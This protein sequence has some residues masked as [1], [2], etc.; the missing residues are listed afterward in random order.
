MISV[1]SFPGRFQVRRLLSGV[2]EVYDFLEEAILFAGECDEAEK[3]RR[4][5]EIQC[6]AFD[7]GAEMPCVA[8]RGQ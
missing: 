2:C 7:P 4:E 8:R 6:R 3:K 5:F 1:E